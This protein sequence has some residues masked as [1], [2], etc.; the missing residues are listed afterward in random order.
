MSKTEAFL[1]IMF[2]SKLSD[3]ESNT[4]YIAGNNIIAVLTI[5]RVHMNFIAIRCTKMAKRAE[6]PQFIVNQIYL[7][8]TII[9]YLYHTRYYTCISGE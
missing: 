2:D 1:G 9:M 8:L 5:F 3:R 6:I 4:P 7:S